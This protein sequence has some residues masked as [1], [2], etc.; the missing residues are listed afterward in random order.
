MIVGSK[1]VYECGVLEVQV[2]S[3]MAA[4]QHGITGSE[5]YPPAKI[6]LLS[7]RHRHWIHTSAVA[8]IRGKGRRWDYR[9]Q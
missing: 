1:F 8:G 9:R 5:S 2:S 4:W 6:P 3:S 7:P